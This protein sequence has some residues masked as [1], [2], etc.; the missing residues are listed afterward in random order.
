LTA[1]TPWAFGGL[2]GAAYGL[3]F[4]AVGVVAVTISQIIDGRAAKYFFGSLASVLGIGALW[5]LAGAVIGV[6]VGFFGWEVSGIICGALLSLIVVIADIYWIIEEFE[7]AEWNLLWMIPGAAVVLALLNWLLCWFPFRMDSSGTLVWAIW[8][9]MIL[10]A[11][12]GLVFTITVWFR[13]PSHTE[14]E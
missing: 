3:L 14:A 13:R 5:G 9:L 10:L 11:M 4:L 12:M 7:D 2:F 6:T 1:N 8:T